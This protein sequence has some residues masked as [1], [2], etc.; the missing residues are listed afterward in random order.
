[1]MTEWSSD[2]RKG[3][4]PDIMKEYHII[5]P[6]AGQGAGKTACTAQADENTVI[7][8]TK[9]PGDARTYLA[10][11][12]RA[13][14]G[15]VRVIVYGGDG[16]IAEAVSGIMDA[17]AAEK[18]V[19]TARP[20]GTGNDFVRMFRD[21][22][23]DTEYRLDVFACNGGNY[24]VNVVNIGFDCTVVDKTAT[25]KTCPFISGTLAYIM[26]VIEVL[27][28]PL[29]TEATVEWVDEAGETHTAEGKFLLCA[30]ANAQYYG[31][32]FRAAPCAD[33]SDGL[34]DLL[35]VRVITRR[36]FFG[37][38][39][40]YHDGKHIGA[41]GKPIPSVADVI[42]YTRCRSARFSGMKQLCRDGEV[43]DGNTL[44][45]TVLP[46]VIRYRT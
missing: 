43:S 3:V 21:T 34:A 18:A 12:L 20:T 1:M 8:E 25:W 28:H 4:L 39:G 44:S 10:E 42:T 26:G 41:D 17:D 23:P 27:C 6:A 38:V 36:R 19:L 11:H 2:D 46:R 16:T 29:G 22:P 45:F 31:G 30:A 13:E 14:A 9:A 40:K 33:A 7:Y 5:N 24:A 32:G 15:E 35:L 37:L